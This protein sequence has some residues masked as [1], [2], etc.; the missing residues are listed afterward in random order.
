MTICNIRLRFVSDFQLDDCVITFEF[1]DTWERICCEVLKKFP[2]IKSTNVSLKLALLSGEVIG[3]HIHDESSFWRSYDKVYNH[4]EHCYLVCEEEK[5]SFRFFASF[6]LKLN[7]SIEISIHSS[8]RSI[9]QQVASRFESI[10]EEFVSGFTILDH[11]TSSNM[12][13]VITDAA[14]FWTQCSNYSSKRMGADSSINILVKATQCWPIPIEIADTGSRHFI[15][16]PQSKIP[17]NMLEACVCS[18]MEVS[19]YAL[20]VSHFQLVDGDGEPIGRHI[21]SADEVVKKFKKIHDDTISDAHF[22]VYCNRANPLRIRGVVSSEIQNA[23]VFHIYPDSTFDNLV[24]Q[25]CKTLNVTPDTTEIAFE[26][27]DKVGQRIGTLDREFFLDE[28]HDAYNFEDDMYIV[29]IMKT[30]Q[31]GAPQKSSEHID[32]DTQAVEKSSTMFES[33]SFYIQ[34][35]ID[36]IKTAQTVLSRDM[37]WND[38]GCTIL[39]C[40]EIPDECSFVESVVLVDEAGDMLSGTL[41]STSHLWKIVD[42]FDVD[43][44][45]TLLLGTRA[46]PDNLT[47]PRDL[48]DAVVSDDCECA[49]SSSGD[50]HQNTDE[51]ITMEEMSSASDV[52]DKDISEAK[53]DHIDDVGLDVPTVEDGMSDARLFMVLF[54]GVSKSLRIDRD[55]GWDKLSSKLIALLKLSSSSHEVNCLFLIDESGKRHLISSISMHAFWSTVDGF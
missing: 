27:W 47:S 3:K 45:L 28:L 15:K 11:N 30:S 6:N 7:E 17:W 8:W 29:L 37:D 55:M 44:P 35:S 48:S 4:T 16:L 13:D 31:F 23:S 49:S 41:Q 18:A 10:N 2:E 36:G 5:I 1:D 38:M 25:F 21:F 22:M 39:S 33:R 9:L 54:D 51:C 52:V 40:L 34:C 50:I 19:L 12:Y 14:A 42:R 20:K 43:E 26:I 32:V 53:S 24:R 46:K